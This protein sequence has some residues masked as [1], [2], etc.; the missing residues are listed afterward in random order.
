[1]SLAS[2]RSQFPDELWV[3]VSLARAPALPHGLWRAFLRKSLVS[4]EGGDRAEGGQRPRVL[5]GKSLNL[6][7]CHP[8]RCTALLGGF[9]PGGSPGGDLEGLSAGVRPRGARR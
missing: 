5:Q 8:L 2:C 1:M 3:F 6:G 7:P 9:L 4:W